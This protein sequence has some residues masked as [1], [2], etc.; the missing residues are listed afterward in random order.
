MAVDAS[1]VSE[2]LTWGDILGA[3]GVILGFACALGMIIFNMVMKRLDKIDNKVDL[4][5]D[6][7]IKV[8]TALNIEDVTRP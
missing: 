1:A 5:S 2:G 8:M 4:T 6:R 7:V 3:I